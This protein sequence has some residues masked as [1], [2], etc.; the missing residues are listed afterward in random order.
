MD[1]RELGREGLTESPAERGLYAVLGWYLVADNVALGAG[2]VTS[3]QAR[4]EY[5]SCGSFGCVN[6]YIRVADGWFGGS[7]ETVALLATVAAL[8]AVPLAFVAR[9]V[10][11]VR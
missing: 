3:A 7:L 4:A 8:A 6:D 1:A 9:R 11:V 5:A 10:F 2:L